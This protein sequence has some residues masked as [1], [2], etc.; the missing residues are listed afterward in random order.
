MAATN[1]AQNIKKDSKDYLTTALMQ[2][3]QHQYLEEITITQV[4][5]RAGVS[6][7]AFYRNFNTIGDLLVEYYQPKIHK[8]FTEIEEMRSQSEKITSLG[9]FFNEISN[10]MILA[11]KHNFEPIIQ[12]IFNQEMIYYYE[13]TIPKDMIGEPIRDY[14]IKFMS[15][16]V[17]T[18]WREWLINGQKESLE[19]IH[20]IIK[21][22]QI[23]TSQ[24]MNK[25]YLAQ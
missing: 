8:K 10:D 3:L 21:G 6:R 4:V 12:Q 1:H 20:D 23:S 11:V 24:Q 17:Y 7:M 9:I 22:L 25:Q 16:G 15:S 13:S 14:W 19:Q 5:K 18:I 2:L